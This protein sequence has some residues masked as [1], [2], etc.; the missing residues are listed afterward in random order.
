M[1]Y[2]PDTTNP[3]T[4]FN[5]L[6][7]A[8]SL[9]WN[10]TV[11]N[12][13]TEYYEQGESDPIP[14]KTQQI[15][16]PNYPEIY[17]E[18]YESFRFIFENG[19]GTNSSVINI[20]NTLNSQGEII[21]EQNLVFEEQINYHNLE[22]H[23]PSITGTEARTRIYKVEG[24]LQGTNTFETIKSYTIVYKIQFI[25]EGN[26]W[27]TP[28]FKNFSKNIANINQLPPSASVNVYTKEAAL[29]FINKDFSASGSALPT[30]INFLGSQAY[31][32]SESIEFSVFLN[33]QADERL[34]EFRANEV[35]VGAVLGSSDSGNII[36]NP[37]R[38]NIFVASSLELFFNPQSF[39]FRIVKGETNPGSQ[40]LNLY[41]GVNWEINYPSWLILN[42]SEGIGVDEVDVEVLD[43]SF[44][45][46]G[47]YENNIIVTVNNTD[48]SIPVSLEVVNQLELNLNKS[49]LNFTKENLNIT[50]LYT[51]HK[52]RY[53]IADVKIPQIGYPNAVA[54]SKT[55]RYRLGFFNGSTEM[56]LG[57]IA[58][59]ALV[60]LEANDV[61][62]LLKLYID[63]KQII[64]DLINY[65]K[66]SLLDVNFQVIDGSTT[67]VLKEHIVKLIRFVKGRNPN[68]RENLALLNINNFT[69][70]VT[71]QSVR[72][73]NFVSR[74][75]VVIEVFKNGELYSSFEKPIFIERLYG[76]M[77]SFENFHQGDYIQ[78]RLYPN[79]IPVTPG[80]YL[81]M[82][83]QKIN[84]IIYPEG[85]HFNQVIF[86]DEYSV[87]Q[88]FDFC[89]DWRFSSSNEII[90]SEKLLNLVKFITNEK[91]TKEYELQ[92]N[93]GYIPASNQAL[94]EQLKNARLCWL[95]GNNAE[96]LVELRPQEYSMVNYDSDQ[97][98]Y[99]Y[100]VTF[101]INPTND[102]QNYS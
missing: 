56:H 78:I 21:N 62:N 95:L 101:K 57:E 54:L 5:P 17:G 67:T 47:L 68:F 93:T 82:K 89:G 64:D 66:P 25:I 55:Y 84:F 94:V 51:T 53:V 90:E 70:K 39:M 72:L 58:D 26:V 3:I 24:Q 8:G 36:A 1:P 65:Y 18:Q 9:N 16:V 102:L 13:D 73:I 37:F 85:K 59:R 4:N 87:P 34:D 100:Q 99:D 77:F 6:P 40:K 76:L 88:F 81:S 49:G 30:P 44:F 14:T 91:S 22:T 15:T 50:K 75:K 32:I 27:I 60:N 98:L 43:E 46:P 28:Q 92:I 2:Y 11:K 48:Y 23:T 45:E 97:D 80:S 38:G 35:I 83:P 74:K 19:L 86:E 31:P 79:N 52:N 96:K 12:Q 42:K 61:Y 71:A 63:D 41:G 33:N 10:F 20:T 69:Q 7:Q 29:I